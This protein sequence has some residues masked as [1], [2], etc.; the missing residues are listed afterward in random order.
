MDDDR[1]RF[2]AMFRQH[3]DAVTRYAVRRLGRTVSADIVSETFLVA[4]RRFDYVPTRVAP[5]S[6]RDY[7]N[8]IRRA[9]KVTMCNRS[10]PCFQR[11]MLVLP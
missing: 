10:N 1:A 2:E 3:Y 7:T 4:W 6:A 5:R 8:L 11:E 9:A